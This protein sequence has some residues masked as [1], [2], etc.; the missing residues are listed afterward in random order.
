MEQFNLGSNRVRFET[1]WYNGDVVTPA[2]IRATQGHCSRPIT[3]PELFKHMIEI[4][5]GWTNA[6]HHSSHQQYVDKIMS[7]GLISGGLGRKEGRQACHFSAAHPQQSNAVLDQKSWQPQIATIYG[8]GLFQAQHMGLKFFPTFSDVFVHFG[9][10]PAERLARVVEHVQTMLSST[11]DHQKS[12]RTHRQSEHMSVHQVTDC[13]TQ[14]NNNRGS[15][16]SG[17][18]KFHF[19]ALHGKNL[20]KKC[21]SIKKGTEVDARTAELYSKQGNTD[22]TEL[23]V[24]DETTSAADTLEKESPAAHVE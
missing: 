10:V 4:P 15:I 21:F 19:Q 22:L 8:I 9:D 14:I 16:S 12:H 17:M 5:H 11:K 6:I 7:N 18:G 1:C 24:S 20:K 3:G 13:L 23:V 2:Y